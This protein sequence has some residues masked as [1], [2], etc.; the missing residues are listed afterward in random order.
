MAKPYDELHG[1]LDERIHYRPRRQRVGELF[2]AESQPTIVIGNNS[3]PVFDISHSGVSFFTEGSSNLEIGQDLQV[4]LEIHG[5]EL[6][7][8][9]ARVVRIESRSKGSKVGL[10]FPRG[11]VDLDDVT[12]RYSEEQLRRELSRGPDPF[13]GAIGDPFRT[14]VTRAYQFLMHTKRV[15][16]EYTRSRGEL[17]N[18]EKIAIARRTAEAIRPAWLE[19]C[20]NASRAAIPLLSDRAAIRAAK[21]FTETLITPLLADCPMV[22]RSY[23][24]PLGYPGDYQVMLYYYENAFEGDSVFAKVFHKFFVE[25]P[26]SNGVVTRSQYVVD[27]ILS[28]LNAK[29]SRASSEQPYRILSIG[30]GPAHEAKLIYANDV[31]GRLEWLLIDQEEEALDVAFQNAK[32]NIAQAN[33]TDGC[34]LFN[35]SFTKLINSPA[36]VLPEEPQDFIFCTGLFDYLRVDKASS[37]LS[38]LY[39]WL[40]PGGVVAIGNA[41]APNTHF[42]SPEFVLDWTLIYRTEDDMR[43]IATKLPDSADVDVTIEPGNAYYF[44]IVQKPLDAKQ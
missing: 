11:F 19:I 29:E 6:H 27:L 21:Q 22:D 33:R 16:S 18:A 2:S 44:L 34:R 17:G 38:A 14:A 30:C 24:K 35:T 10:A 40:A 39:D 15:L 23:N 5:E 42:W 32:R 20:E 3:Y 43:Q 28:E 13:N 1:A 4:N 9:A 25:H 36:E 26:L 37:L 12:E 31:P 8:D 41:L 7:S